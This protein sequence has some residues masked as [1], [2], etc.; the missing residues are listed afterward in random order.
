MPEHGNK[1]NGFMKCALCL[2]G[3]EKSSIALPYE[4]GEGLMIVVKGVPAWVCKQCGDS[5]VDI[6][7]VRDLERIVAN[8]R[9]NG[10]TLGFIDYPQAA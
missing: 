1:E 3:M 5:F 6:E 9:R 7:I 2:G 10:V 4:M 8:A